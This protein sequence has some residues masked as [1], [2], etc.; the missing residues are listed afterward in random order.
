MKKAWGLV[1]VGEEEDDLVDAPHGFEEGAKKRNRKGLKEREGIIK[2]RKRI[3]I[4]GKED[5]VL[6]AKH[7]STTSNEKE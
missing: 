7:Q 2:K 1:G 6:L 3:S 5:I 4:G